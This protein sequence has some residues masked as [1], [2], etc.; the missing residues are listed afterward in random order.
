[1]KNAS[2]SEILKVLLSVEEAMGA[3]PEK[4]KE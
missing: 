2:L 4:T 3:N 1:M